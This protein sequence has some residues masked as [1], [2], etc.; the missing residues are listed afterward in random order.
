MDNNIEVGLFR[1]LSPWP[2]TPWTDGPSPDGTSRS[3]PE[4]P[5]WPVSDDEPCLEEDDEVQGQK[6]TGTLYFF[7]FTN[8][9]WPRWPSRLL[10]S[11]QP[12]VAGF[13]GSDWPLFGGDYTFHNSNWID[14]ATTT[15]WRVLA[16]IR[17]SFSATIELTASQRF[18]FF[19]YYNLK[20]FNA[21]IWNTIQ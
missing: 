6:S 15:K 7:G 8:V 17:T 9:S 21:I 3:H 4:P 14:F 2:R 13:L 12:T 11:L 1:E 20:Y 18:F 10:S 5:P 19:K 16:E